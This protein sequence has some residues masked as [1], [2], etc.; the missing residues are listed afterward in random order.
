MAKGPI[1]IVEDHPLNRELLA[2]PLEAAGYTV[3]QADTG[4]DLLARVQTERPALILMD[5]QMP[6]L[7]GFTLVRQLKAEPLTRGV[8]IVAITAYAQ[9]EAQA[10][11]LEVGCVGYFS[12]PLDT[13]RLVQT[14]ALLLEQ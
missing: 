7:D 10:R 1:L 2:A 13:E 9:P 5:L 12:K 3:L 4:L 14:V 6:Q 11:A 8:P